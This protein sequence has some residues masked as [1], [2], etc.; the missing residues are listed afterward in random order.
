MFVFVQVR[1]CSLGSDLDEFPEKLSSFS[2]TWSQTDFGDSPIL[3]L[4]ESFHEQ[5][6]I[7][8]YL[9]IFVSAEDLIKKFVLQ[10]KQ[11]EFFKQD[12]RQSMLV[13]TTWLID[14]NN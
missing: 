12:E 8:R 4:I 14:M 10:E 1:L 11:R 9:S 5:I 3:N 6:E 7:R 13:Q 2:W